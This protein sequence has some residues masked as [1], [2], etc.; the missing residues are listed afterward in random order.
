MYGPLVPQGTP[1]WGVHTGPSHTDTAVPEMQ[2]MQH[3]LGSG[4]ATWV[5][6]RWWVGTA[7]HFLI[8]LGPYEKSESGSPSPSTSSYQQYGGGGGT[9]ESRGIEREAQTKSSKGPTAGYSRKRPKSAHGGRRTGSK[10][11]KGKRFRR[12]CGKR[13]WVKGELYLCSKLFKHR[14]DHK[15]TYR[16]QKGKR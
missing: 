2:E 9:G 12:F 4:I 16:P 13:K 11:R 3:V 10:P 7:I 5:I 6:K 1:R 15:Y 14:G 8:H